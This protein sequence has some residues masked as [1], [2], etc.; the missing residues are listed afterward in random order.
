MGFGLDGF[1]AGW[2][3]ALTQGESGFGLGWFFSWMGWPKSKTER[4]DPNARR[5][6]ILKVDGSVQILIVFICIHLPSLIPVLLTPATSYPPSPPP[7][8]LPTP[9]LVP[10]PSSFVIK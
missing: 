9:L 7:L 5:N 8:L 1:L 6:P 10:T 3:G 4:N 2:G